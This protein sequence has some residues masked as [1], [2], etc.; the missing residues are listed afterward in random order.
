MAKLKM[1]ISDGFRTQAGTECFTRT[2][3]A[4]EA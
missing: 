1:K 3:M 4:G 2:P